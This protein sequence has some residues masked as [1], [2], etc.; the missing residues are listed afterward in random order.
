[1]WGGFV[2]FKGWR[3]LSVFVGEKS[4]IRGKIDNGER[5]DR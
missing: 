1:M 3:R 2:L 5:K 4:Q